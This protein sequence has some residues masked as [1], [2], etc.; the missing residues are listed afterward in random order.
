MIQKPTLLS[1]YPT[2][3][4]EYHCPNCFLQA[5]KDNTKQE[6]EPEF[7]VELI[8]VAK[9][10]G[11][12]DVAISAN[13]VFSTGDKNAYYF[14]RLKKETLDCGLDFSMTCNHDF[15]DRYY[16]EKDFNNISLISVSIN[17]FV[18][19]TDEKKQQAIESMRKMKGIA[20]EINC[21]ILLSDNMVKHLNNGLAEKILE[22]S[23]TIY[24]L[25]SQPLLVPLQSIYQL[26]GKIKPELMKLLEDRIFINSCINREMGLTGGVCSKHDFIHISPYGE[27]KMCAYDKKNSYTLEKA[28]DLEYIYDKG[29]PLDP[30]NTCDLLTGKNI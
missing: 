22:V 10:I 24:L 14:D 12:K 17:D 21:N 23:N 6:R 19:S 30:L 16:N 1:I 28:S 25:S 18:T 20:K 8:R 3:Q 13:N 2:A 29:Y 15:I 26:I 4:C 9:K 5:G 27:I 11:M 7:F